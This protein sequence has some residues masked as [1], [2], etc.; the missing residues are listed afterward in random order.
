MNTVEQKKIE[1]LLWEK[2]SLFFRSNRVAPEA[3]ETPEIEVKYKNFSNSGRLATVRGP[4]AQRRN[5]TG[6]TNYGLEESKKVG[7]IV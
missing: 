1:P 2:V 6:N 5:S 3:N 7:E 4:G